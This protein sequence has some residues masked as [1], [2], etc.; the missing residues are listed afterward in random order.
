MISHTPPLADEGSSSTRPVSGGD[1]A[2]FF[3]KR[4]I[5]NKEGA[6][7]TKERRQ[8]ERRKAKKKEGKDP[9]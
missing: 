3:P 9:S 4:N 5:V 8:K 6:K 7:K 1:G 2:D